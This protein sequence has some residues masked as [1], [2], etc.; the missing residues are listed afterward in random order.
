MMIML[1][2][3]Y[4]AFIIGMA[5]VSNTIPRPTS[6]RAA[7]LALVNAVANC[8]SIYTPY[9]YPDSSAPRFVLAM[10]VNAGTSLLSIV[11]A[12]VFRFLLVRENKKLEQQDAEAEGELGRTGEKFRYL[13]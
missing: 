2:G 12:S 13:L 4:T 5:W 10:S 6:K 1:P 3:V 7:A 8:S 9:L 11:T